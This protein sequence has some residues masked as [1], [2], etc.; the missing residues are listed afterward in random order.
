MNTYILNIFKLEQIKENEENF[1][2]ET[3]LDSDVYFFNLS[4]AIYFAQNNVTQLTDL[5]ANYITITGIPTGTI[6]NENT[7]KEFYVLEYVSETNSYNEIDK[8]NKIYQYLVSKNNIKIETNSKPINVYL[9]KDNYNETPTIN[10]DLSKEEI[11]PTKEFVSSLKENLENKDYAKV[12]EMIE[13]KETYVSN[14]INGFLNKVTESFQSVDKT[15]NQLFDV[16]N[17][18]F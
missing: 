4:D 5:D 18:K 15:I 17:G 9:G 7:L 12:K 3:K 8:D 16:L 1:Y 10:V 2:K 11:M 13:Q 14:E 6:N